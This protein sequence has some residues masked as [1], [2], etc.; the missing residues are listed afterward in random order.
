VSQIRNRCHIVVLVGG[1]WFGK[2]VELSHDPSPVLPL[3]AGL[4]PFIRQLTDIEGE[5]VFITDEIINILYG[6]SCSSIGQVIQIPS[7][8]Q[9]ISLVTVQ[10]VYDQLLDKGFIR[11][12]TIISLEGSVV[13][14][15]A[16][17]VAGT[18]CGA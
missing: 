11:S 1:K 3:Y 13:G 18:I 2:A 6:P 9:N 7:R 17:Y 15:I 4:L 5:I 14:D 10:S 8:R 12:G 16:G